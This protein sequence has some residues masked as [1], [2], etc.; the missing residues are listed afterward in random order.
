MIPVINLFAVATLIWHSDNQG[1]LRDRGV[2]LLKALVANPLIIGCLLGIIYARLSGVFPVFIDNSLQLISM[3]TLPLALVSI[4]GALSFKGVRKFLP[5]S[6]LAAF[7]KLLVLPLIG[8]TIYNLFDISGL[9]FRTGMIFL[10]LPA[11][12]AIYVL[13]SQLNSDTDLASAAIVVST[14]ISFGSLSVALL[15]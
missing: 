12:T 1:S 15:L 10:C 6:L 4:G 3:V 14:V 2:L 8:Y 7:L 9:P 13:S 11:S 5:L